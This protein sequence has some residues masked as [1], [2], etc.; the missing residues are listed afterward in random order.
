MRNDTRRRVQPSLAL[1]ACGPASASLEVRLAQI[2]VHRVLRHPERP[3]DADRWQL[4]AVNEPIDG[5]LR[6]PH[7]SGYLSDSEETHVGEGIPGRA[8]DHDCTNF[9]TVGPLLPRGGEQF[10][11][12]VVR[13]VANVTVGKVGTESGEDSARSDEWWPPACRLQHA[14]NSTQF[15]FRDR[16][17]FSGR[18]PARGGGIRRPACAL[19]TGP[20][21]SPESNRRPSLRRL[22][23]DRPS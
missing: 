13:V 20:V 17:P 2:L 14:H 21:R 12:L 22:A 10:A 18:D 16:S 11:M 9:R 7:R 23:D 6:D 15:H 4:A 5:H 8:W 3:A 1:G 19:C